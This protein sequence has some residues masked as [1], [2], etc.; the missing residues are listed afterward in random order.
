MFTP[1]SRLSFAVSFFLTTFLTTLEVEL[2]AWVDGLIDVESGSRSD[3]SVTVLCW[4]GS[5]GG[6]IAALRAARAASASCSRESDKSR[7]H[8]K[9]GCGRITCSLPCELERCRDGCLGGT[10]VDED[11][12]CFG[13]IEKEGYLCPIKAKRSHIL[14]V[15][16][17]GERLVE[18]GERVF[19]VP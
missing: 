13:S 12:F 2:I 4:G 16:P 6:T 15:K 8:D 19:Q 1:R 11:V 18:P 17:T 9:N 10:S 5:G 14:H 7:T 3:L